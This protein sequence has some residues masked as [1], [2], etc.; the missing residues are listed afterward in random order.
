M[1][2]SKQVISTKRLQID[3]ARANVVMVIAIAS[4]VA[5]FSL[6]SA[7]ALLTKRSF[8]NRVID[9]K[10]ITLQTL[11]ANNA[12]AEQLVTSYKA[13]NETP[14]NLIGGNPKGTGDRDGEN[15]KL[16]LDAL[17]SEYDFPGLTSS[18]AKIVNGSRLGELDSFT[19]TDDEVAQSTQTDSTKPVEIPFSVSITTKEG[20]FGGILTAFNRSIR[21]MTI[22]KLSISS[23]GQAGE[24]S[25]SIDG[26][27]YY[28]PQKSLSITQK[29]VR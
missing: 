9:Q 23:S 14:D 22:D 10:K 17:P 13:F 8:Q 24:L 11:Q 12:A 27:T 3:K 26:K 7:R 25:L 5:V 28:Q 15:A 20:A 21:P 16:V 2:I 1:G 6:V 19:G 29:E 4:F 18:I